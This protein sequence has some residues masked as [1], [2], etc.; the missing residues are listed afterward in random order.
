MHIDDVYMEGPT[1]RRHIIP[2]GIYLVSR[3]PAAIQLGPFA[4]SESCSILYIGLLSREYAH[5]AM[6]IYTHNK[7]YIYHFTY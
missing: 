6:L 1:G 4:L 3:G 2:N 5:C 7:T